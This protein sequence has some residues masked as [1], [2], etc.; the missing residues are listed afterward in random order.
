[1]GVKQMQLIR[2]SERI[3]SGSE[4]PAGGRFHGS[5]LAQTLFDTADKTRVSFVHFEPG[6]HTMWHTHSGGQLLHIVEGNARVQPWGDKI[7]ELAAGDTAIAP[8]GEKHWHG[9]SLDAGMTQMAITSGDVA[10]LEDV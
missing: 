6:A 2:A 9:A 10:W 3:P 1:M 4:P 5:A 7:H 8:P